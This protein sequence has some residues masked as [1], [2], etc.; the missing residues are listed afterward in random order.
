MPNS[1][2]QRPG[3][4][5]T[6]RQYWRS[7]SEQAGNE[8][9]QRYL[10]RAESA[11]GA[12]FSE[13]NRRDFLRLLGASLALAGV[14]GCLR[15]PE[16]K[17]VPYVQQPEEIVPG[18]PLYFATAMTLGG[19]ATGLLVESHMGRPTKIEGNPRH[20]SVPA[21]PWKGNP[22]E[23][24]GVSDAFAQAA[25][26]TMYDPDRSQT[27]TR[28]GEI[29]TW[30]AF[31]SA[32]R[33]VLEAQRDRQGRGIRLLTETITSPT[34]ADQI[35]RFL[36]TYPEAQWVQY[37]P[38]NDDNALAG[39]QMA[40][41]RYVAPRYD[42]DRADVILALDADFLIEGP[43]HLRQAHAFA[44]R[45]D[46]R[47][48][49]QSPISMSRLY[50]VESTPTLT[51]G[52]ADHRLALSSA[53]IETFLLAL[54]SRLEIDVAGSEENLPKRTRQWLDAV[55]DDL[56][57]YRPRGESGSALVLAGRWLS[58]RA[59][60][61][62]HA[63]NE[64]LGAVGQTVTYAEPALAEPT[65]QYRA[66]AE[67]VEDMRAGRVETLCILG[68]NP[69]YA[70][71]GNLDFAA[72]LAKVPF[73]VRLGL[74]DDETS[75]RCDWHLPQAH[76]LESWDDA[77]A[78]DGT[79]SIVQPLIAPLYQGR[80]PT[81][82]MAALLG[83]PGKT[84][85]EIV[86][87][88]W[89][90]QIGDGGDFEATWETSLHDGVV[91]ETQ[92]PTVSV[93][94]DTSN[95]N[96]SPS[97][98]AAVASSPNSGTEHLDLV[99]R[100]DPTIWDG[101]FANNG[102]L[103]ELPKPFTKLTWDN[104]A[105]MSPGLASSLRLND[106]D[107]VQ[108]EYDG[109]SVTAPVW[110]LPG[111]SER[112]VTLPLGYGRR[113]AGQV[114]RGLGFD[115]YALQTI[116]SP[117]H[118]QGATL[119][120][121]GQSVDLACTQHH[122]W[123][124]GRD[125]V[126]SG[127]LAEVQQ[128]PQHPAFM[129]SEHAGDLP[130]LYPEFE[131]DGHKWAMSIDLNRCTGCNACVAACQSENNIPVVGKEQ[132]AMGREMHWI[133]VD[134]YYEGDVHQPRVVHQPLPCMHCE[135]APCEV[136]CPVAATVHDEEGLNEMVY[137]RCVGTRYCSNN[138][139]YKVR[140]FNYL[141]YSELDEPTLKM[142][143]N[144]DVTVRNRGVMEKCTYCVQRIAAARI[145]ADNSG[146]PIE[147]GQIVTACQAA[148][149]SQAI[150]FGDLNDAESRVHSLAESPLNY[151]LLGELNTRPRTTYLAGVRNP[152]PALEQF[153]ADSQS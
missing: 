2:P 21:V 127:T 41:G 23:A 38:V 148:C 109:R 125:L 44:A 140:R 58:P 4:S 6:S 61:V 96:G 120:R 142:M 73:R 129:H 9:L 22:H 45:R 66:F 106:G 62:V 108:I 82:I 147:D 52:K 94:V 101:R 83:E 113:R 39:A 130:S 60:A 55:A 151:A 43:D 11:V 153:E 149:P 35:R 19:F 33:P 87:Q 14:Q 112:T 103:Q 67:L 78:Y 27:F 115:A 126:R 131:Y 7:L 143:Q 1:A 133:R 144:P 80:T 114:G 138:C 90:Q 85:H 119:R 128:D 36:A 42:V 69:V 99:F 100:P 50:A 152:N 29:S 26:L 77:R 18:K 132:V 102:W 72:A 10:A 34:L 30:D 118:G 65:L 145:D 8:E 91:A 31:V 37:E 5:E 64:K 121:L 122:H 13:S 25:I 146:H 17:I 76:F 74:Y 51:G 84:A 56:R 75:A 97:D 110:R 32:L 136:V 135:K 79:A 15:Q 92:A 71:P 49:A 150:V 47:D 40:F 93:T 3:P 86:K 104:A 89:Q 134:A 57:N 20:P 139:P 111:Q 54:A 95:L 24:P 68:G 123:M 70:S 107:L 46:V 48:P 137:N 63:I 88:Y 16:E 105:L 28:A 141:Q 53:E 81:E 12:E 116:T 98:A 59:H 124:D 117:W